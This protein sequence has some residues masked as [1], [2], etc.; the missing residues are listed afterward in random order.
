L[1][2]WMTDKM[3]KRSYESIWRKT[4]D[5]LSWLAY[6]AN[7][8]ARLLYERYFGRRQDSISTDDQS[9]VCDEF[10]LED[11]DTNTFESGP[12]ATSDPVRAGLGLSLA[13]ESSSQDGRALVHVAHD[14]VNCS[15]ENT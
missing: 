12:V 5:N 4:E 6:L 11:T 10:D 2:M 3:D 1:M 15:L 7:T 9:W 8:H 13:T 14:R